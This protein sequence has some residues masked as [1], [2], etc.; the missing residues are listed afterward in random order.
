MLSRTITRPWELTT[1]A[2]LRQYHNFRLLWL[3]SVAE[4]GGQLIEMLGISWLLYDM[5]GSAFYLMLM[6]FV[7]AV[8]HLFLP[9]LGGVVADRM[10]RRLLLALT[11]AGMAAL[12]L[13]LT[14]L[15]YMGTV[16]V[17]HIM[18]ISLGNGI[19]ISFNHPARNTLVPNV[20]RREHLMNAV[21]LDT[22]SVNGSRIVGPPVAGAMIMLFGMSS[23]FGFRALGALIAMY[24]TF[25]LQVP[26]TPPQARQLGWGQN[27][28]EGL[29]YIRQSPV[30]LTLIVLFAIPTISSMQNLNVAPIFAKDILQVGEFG[31]GLMQGALGLGSMAGTLGIASLGTDYRHKGWLLFIL[32]IALGGT[33]ALFAVTPWF[34]PSLFVLGGI[35]AATTA[36]QAAVTTNLQN[37]ISDEMRGRVMSVREILLGVGPFLALGLGAA[38]DVYGAILITALAGLAT[39]ALIVAVTSIFP[40]VRRLE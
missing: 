36:Y 34:I 9:P 10:D 22:A 21:A 5:T 15:V 35:G 2:S 14:I 17:W 31:L 23:V 12:S 32:G 38:I 39:V 37:V 4:H 28:G 27:F 29:A 40:T 24:T 11:L 20:V 18:A 30:V 1:F 33:I 19:L 16:E 3:G 25:L 7:R 26:P 8:P 13:W 6:G